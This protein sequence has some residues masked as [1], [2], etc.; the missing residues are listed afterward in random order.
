MRFAHALIRE[1][2]YDGAAARRGGAR[3]TGAAGEALA[4][5]PRPDPDAV[6]YHFQRA[7]D[8][9]AAAWLVAGGRAGASAP[10][11]G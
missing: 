7:G 5:T 9:R 3:C 2:L 8:A 1:A 10:T 6:A 11:P 4:A